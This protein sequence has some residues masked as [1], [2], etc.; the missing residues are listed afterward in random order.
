[1][2]RTAKSPV[3]SSA[4]RVG[5]LFGRGD[6]AEFGEFLLGEHDVGCRKILIE[7]RR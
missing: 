7:V 5:I 4:A 3:S 6:L 1:M 2:T